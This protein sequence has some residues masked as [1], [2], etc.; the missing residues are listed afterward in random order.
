MYRIENLLI[1]PNMYKN[2]KYKNKMREKLVK[3]VLLEEK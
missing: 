1:D 2:I 3:K